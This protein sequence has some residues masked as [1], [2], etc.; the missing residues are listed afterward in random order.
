[1]LAAPTRRSS[2][3]FI[4]AVCALIGLACVWIGIG[5]LVWSFLARTFRDVFLGALFIGTGLGNLMLMA[6]MA[7]RAKVRLLVAVVAPLNVIGIVWL[8]WRIST[9]RMILP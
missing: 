6:Q 4:A 7:R 3:T 1:M 5:V 2:V 9:F 8:A